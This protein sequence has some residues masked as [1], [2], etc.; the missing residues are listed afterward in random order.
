MKEK[1]IEIKVIFGAVCG[2]FLIFLGA[3]IATLLLK[4]FQDTGG[5]LFAHYQKVLGGKGFLTAFGN[6]LLIAG[7]SAAVT[8]FFAFILAY[9]IHYT[10]IPDKGKK[11]IKWLAVMPM[12]LPT[13]TYGFAIIYSFGK[14]GLITKI[15]GRQLFD[16]YGFWGLLLGYVIYTLPVAFLLITNTM[17][18]IDKKF[19]IVSRIMGDGKIKNFMITVLRPMTGTLAAAFIQCFF[20]AFTDFGIPASVGG[21]FETIASVLY[22]EMLGS[23]PDFNRGAVVAMVMLV[24]SIISISVLQYLERY[25]IRYNKISIVENPGN[26]GRDWGLGMVSGVILFL[27]LMVFAVIFIVPFVNGWPYDMTATMKHFTSVLKDR[28]LLRVYENSL[29]V[30]VMTAAIG[31]VVAY[32]AAL[33]TARSKMTAKVKGI[34][35]KIAL[36]TNTIPG[37]VLGISFLFV[38][39]GTPLQNTFPLII[40][41]NVVHFF[42]TPYLMLKNSLQKMNASWE[43]TAMLMGDSWLQTIYRVVTPNALPTLIEVFSYYFINAMVTVSA[44]I[45]IAGA[46]TMVITTKI[47]ELQY[48]A[49]F[50]EIFVLSIFILLTNLAAKGIFGAMVRLREKHIKGDK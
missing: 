25:N 8:T 42:S 14:Q 50:N 46:R 5:G 16:I 23:I 21:T 29:L 32:G 17:G 31:S 30:A 38:F 34:I 36:I 12:L 19:S 33:V 37:M 39:T 48:F 45:F 43:T 18:Y 35:E 9:T 40:L 47:K 26:K 6:S 1:N 27:L 44:I 10:N 7:I 15:A 20:L 13:I 22:F 4:S 41:C 11:A 24:P 28:S 3:P 2:L 49:K